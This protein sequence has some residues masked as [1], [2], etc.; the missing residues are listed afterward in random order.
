[1]D[2]TMLPIEQITADTGQPRSHADSEALAELAASIRRHGV[3]NPI[4]V[5][6]LPSGAGYR[7]VTGE[8]R[9]RAAQMAGLTAMPCIIRQ[10]T[11]EDVRVQQLIENMQR[12]DLQPL[13]RARGIV[14]LQDQTGAS[15]RDVAAMLGISERSVHNLLDLMDLPGDIG[16]RIVSSP[17]KPAQGQLTEKHARFIK[18][19]AEEPDLQR[20]VADRIQRD[21][22][23]SGDTETMVRALRLNP[24]DAEEILTAPREAFS[25]YLKAKDAFAEERRSERDAEAQT[26]T[27]TGDVVRA[28]AVA[29]DN[30]H[31][32]G[33]SPASLADLRAALHQARQILDALDRECAMEMG[34]S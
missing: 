29:L 14:A 15:I 30:I 21:R 17:N 26:D 3:L 24:E 31:P 4:T 20:R 16:E 9:W 2:I 34:E 13:D 7:I 22:L 33:L 11:E 10:L 32:V 27:S 23:T 18:Q 5:A 1:M 25:G 8:R 28:C 12:E 6:E 19:L